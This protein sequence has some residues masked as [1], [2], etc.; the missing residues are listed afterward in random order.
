[1]E[2]INKRIFKLIDKNNHLSDSGLAAFLGCSKAAVSKWRHETSTPHSKFLPHIA[3]YLHTSQTYLTTG[4][5][6]PDEFNELDGIYL[7]LAKE[8]Q[9]NAIDPD[10]IRMAIKIIRDVREKETK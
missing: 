3:E 2:T 1:M 6:A 9:D 8:A 10:D 7:S 5:D 4:K